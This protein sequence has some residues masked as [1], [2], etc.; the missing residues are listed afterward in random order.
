MIPKCI[1][2][3]FGLEP[4]F[5]RAPF[6]FVHYLAVLSAKRLNPDYTIVMHYRYE[7]H[8]EHWDQAKQLCNLNQLST[9]PTEVHGKRII[10]MAHKADVVRMDILLAEG[11]IYLDMDTICIAPFYPLLNN[12]CVMGLE[13]FCG[14]INGLCNAVIMAEQQSE[15]MLKW[16]DRYVDFD[17]N[18]WVRSSI[19][20]PYVIACQHQDLIHVEPSES[21]FRLTWHED[22]AILM[23][24]KTIQ[25]ERSY[26]AHL[27]ENIL[28]EKY[29]RGINF[30]DVWGRDSSYNILARK[31][32]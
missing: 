24:K 15:F 9:V 5:G 22:D 8:N 3:I 18:N 11:G 12:R 25:F 23:H 32:L 16:K 29:L 17:P 6:S 27:W 26:S 14:R 19:Y 4:D 10:H 7:P 13:I 2:F 1:H 31:C 21:F 28:Y 20:E 30:D